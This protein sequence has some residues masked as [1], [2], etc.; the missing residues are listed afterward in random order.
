MTE[1]GPIGFTGATG[2]TGETGLTGV[3][4][5]GGAGPQGAP[6]PAGETGFTGPTGF[7]G[8]TGPTGAPGVP[9]DPGT[10]GSPGSAGTPGE[11]ITG[12]TGPIG[13]QGPLGLKGEQGDSVIGSTGAVGDQGI[14]LTGNTGSTG[15]TGLQGET[16]SGGPTGTTGG[17]GLTGSVGPTG[18]G[19]TGPTG[20]TAGETGNTGPTGSVGNLGTT[21]STGGQGIP[22]NP[23]PQGETGH[24]GTIGPRGV[25]GEL[26][27]TGSSGGPIGETGPAGVPGPAGPTGG[28][29]FHGALDGLT[30]T[31]DHPQYVRTDASRGFENLADVD[32]VLTFDS[33]LPTGPPRNTQLV[34]STNGTPIWIISKN[35][36]RSLVL[37]AAE[38]L[39]AVVVLSADASASSI[40]V[41]AS[42]NVGIGTASPGNK[43][44]VL[45]S[46][47]IEGSELRVDNNADADATFTVDSGQT[48]AFNSQIAFADRGFDQW[49]VRKDALNELFIQR[50]ADPTPIIRFKAG[51]ITDLDTAFTKAGA[52]PMDIHA[53][54]ARHGVGG[55]DIIAGLFL[56]IQIGEVAVPSVSVGDKVTIGPIDLSAGGRTG[57]QKVLLIGTGEITTNTS[58]VTEGAVFRLR[59]DGTNVGLTRTITNTE[60]NSIDDDR[61]SFTVMA[62]VDNVTAASHSFHLRV[63]SVI[64]DIP[65]FQNFS[66]LF[67]DLGP[68]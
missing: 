29:T 25:Q 4:V 48:S 42:G 47:R 24:S 31:D 22:G 27:P 12:S 1:I 36:S 21:G 60:Q 51:N 58:F 10:P 7:T 9:G 32:L 57:N 52:D 37:Q 23:G 59:I 43:L 3:G 39:K 28:I 35:A 11:S 5:T 26:G 54:A 13:P 50:V 14:S 34:L 66:L 56:D 63:D 18:A 40:V 41:D 46:A 67:V 61:D 19:V 20:A 2:S 55:A 30:A 62:L 68:A 15:P 53:H 44:H 38:S 49:V 33:G 65:T 17:V 6:A 8:F 16:G 45:G 64:G